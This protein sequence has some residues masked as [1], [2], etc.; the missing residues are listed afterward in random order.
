MRSTF[1]FRNS[2]FFVLFEY[3]FKSRVKK[4]HFSKR[5]GGSSYKFVIIFFKHF[6][7]KIVSRHFLQ[8]SSVSVHLNL[9]V[10]KFHFVQR[11]VKNDTVFIMG[12]RKETLL[13]LNF[14]KIWLRIY[15]Q[16]FCLNASKIWIIKH[17]L[18]NFAG[19]KHYS[20]QLNIYI[21]TFYLLYFNIVYIKVEK[22]LNRKVRLTVPYTHYFYIY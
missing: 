20:I 12:I 9:K 11:L 5:G 22:V 10:E 8:P 18:S 14:W 16:L 19:R 2:T 13:M 1:S 7:M 21:F 6:M 17:K 15:K 3:D 4:N